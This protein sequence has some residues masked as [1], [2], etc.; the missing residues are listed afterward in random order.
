M[1]QDPVLVDDWHAIA[2]ATEVPPD[3]PYA[4][5]LLGEDLVIWRS[6][7]G[8]HVWRDLCVHRGARLSAGSI[9]S[10]CLTCAY[11]GWTYNDA[12][13]CTSIPAHPS[14]EPPLKAQARTYR[15][16]E[17]YGLI[18][19]SLGSPKAEVPAFSEW[20]DAN[21]RKVI[22]GPYFVKAH[23]PRIIENF[24]DV[25][26]FPFVHEGLLGDAARP[27]IVDYEATITPDGVI[28]RDVRIW[29][30]NPDGSGVASEVSYTYQVLRPLT[31]YFYKCHGEKRYS[32]I[33]TVV[34][35][36]ETECVARMILA[37]N[38]A[39]EV[40]DEDL[41]LFQDRITAQDVPIVESQRPELLP[42]DLQQ[43]LHLR[44]DRTAIAYRQW[45]KQ[46]GMQY[47]IA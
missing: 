14:L 10:D 37:L 7:S 42:L 28:A 31:A 21:F 38:Y 34:P 1:I 27:E 41:R 6:S 46:I 43:E 22:C 16:Q 13:R 9:R 39:S 44:S 30:P 20:D 2:S 33:E 23:G 11:H 24:L 29:Q 5:R 32:I 19:A 47:G 17:R 3:R 4:A 40:P 15:S 18:W 36:S 8:L 35:V 25:G 26:H 12:G 45:L